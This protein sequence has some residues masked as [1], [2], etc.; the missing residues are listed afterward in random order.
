VGDW[1]AEVVFPSPLGELRAAAT[2][3]G[4]VR[5]GFS[6]SGKEHAAWLARHFADHDRAPT[7]PAIDQLRAQ[8]GEYFE[9]RRTRFDL[10]LDLMGT[11]FQC[12]VWHVLQQI[13]Y[14]ET[15]TYRQLAQQLGVRARCA[16]SAPPTAPIR[17]RSS[18]PATAS[19][20]AAASWAATAVAST[21]SAACWP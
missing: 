8:L 13:P 16:R 15:W 7:L 4:L 10:R 5:I 6:R 3:R 20:P 2:E 19:W 17:S 14:G 11:P 21:S 1:L 9:L 12:A 18:C